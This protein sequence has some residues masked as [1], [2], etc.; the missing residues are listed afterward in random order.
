[1]SSQGP[2]DTLWG[3]N[4]L[5][6]ATV[7]QAPQAFDHFVHEFLRAGFCTRVLV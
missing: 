3:Q 2:S 5:A 6:S 4:A 7:L 1:M